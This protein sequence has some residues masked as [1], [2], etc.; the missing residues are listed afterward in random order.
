DIFDKK[1]TKKK[2][3]RAIDDIQ[4]YQMRMYEADKRQNRRDVRKIN[5]K[6]GEFYTDMESIK[7]RKK[8]GKEW[9]K[10]G[11]VDRLIEIIREAAPIIKLIAKLVCSLIISF[12]SIEAVKRAISPR[13]LSKIS[14]LF[15]LASAV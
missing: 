8:I 11:F 7:C 13:L 9:E 14:I 12:L 4:T 3:A 6:E 15:D 1:S 10:T 2:F 5:K